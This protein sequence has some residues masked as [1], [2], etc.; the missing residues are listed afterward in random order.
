MFLDYIIYRLT[1]A[2]Q[3][4]CYCGFPPFLWGGQCSS[5]ICLGSSCYYA[6]HLKVSQGIEL[7]SLGFGSKFFAE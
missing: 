2:R 7:R 5:A 3:M 4:L 6:Q 1:H